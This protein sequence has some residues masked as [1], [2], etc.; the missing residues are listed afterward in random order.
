LVPGHLADFFHLSKID[1]KVLAQWKAQPI[2]EV[3]TQPLKTRRL[4]VRPQSGN[5]INEILNPAEMELGLWSPT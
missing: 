1:P 4:Q 3:L 2:L 5:M